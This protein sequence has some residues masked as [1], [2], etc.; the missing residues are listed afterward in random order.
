[1]GVGVG[2]EEGDEFGMSTASHVDLSEEEGSVSSVMFAESFRALVQ[3]VD[4]VVMRD[5]RSLVRSAKE[6][7]RD[8]GWRVLRICWTVDSI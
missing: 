7:G 8:S 5:R 2:V 6:V 1:M 3:R 4:E